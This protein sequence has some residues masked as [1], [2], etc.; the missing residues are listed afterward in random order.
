MKTREIPTQTIFTR[1]FVLCFFGQFTFTFVAHIFIPTLPIYLVRLGSNEIEIGFLIGVLG[2]SSLLLRPFIGR[3][4]LRIAEKKFMIGGAFLYTLTSLAYLFAVPFW[5]FFMVR[6]FQGMGHAFFQT[7]SV[8]LIANIIPAASRGQ[9]L[10][11]FYLAVNMA[12]ALAPTSGMILINHYNFTVLFLVCTGISLCS[13]FITTKMGKEKVDPVEASS[14]KDGSLLSWKALPPS[15]VSFFN[16]VI[17]GA[18]IAFFPLYAINH[19]VANPGLFF[20]AHAI[21]LILARAFGG[22]LLD[23]YR[24]ETVILPCLATPIIS[25]GI[26]AFSTTLPMFIWVAVI[27]GIGRSLI[28][29]ALVAYTLDRVGSSRG[30]AMGTFTAVGD[31]GTSL[32]PAIMGI[33][34]HSTSYPTMFLCLA[35]VGLLN[36]SYFYFFMRQK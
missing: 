19:G 17:W 24:R 5:P 6:A 2:V 23:L 21:V 25:M 31:L 27:L 33:I 36:L 22:K 30:P 35:F 9:S 4:L 3:A 20:A 12:M 26:L 10:S 1:D 13:L 28:L 15:I 7:A 29:P 8:T 32:G 11:Y 14:T 18:L 16:H 34:L